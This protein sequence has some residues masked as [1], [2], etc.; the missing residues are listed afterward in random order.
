MDLTDRP[1]LLTNLTGKSGNEKVIINFACCAINSSLH[2][3]HSRSY[4]FP[5]SSPRPPTTRVSTSTRHS[6]SKFVNRHTASVLANL[7][8]RQVRGPVEK[9][10]KVSSVEGFGTGGRDGF[11]GEAKLYGGAEGLS[12]EV[13]G[14]SVVQ[15]VGR[16]TSGSGKDSES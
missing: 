11:D 15:R 3:L 12:E 7:C 5:F 6:R 4:S 10:W 9:P 1:H 8:P 14:E 16:K 2:F 13:Y